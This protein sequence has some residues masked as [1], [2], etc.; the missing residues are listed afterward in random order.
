MGSFSLLQGIFPT[1]GLNS[2]LPH[3]RWIL[4]QLSHKG[5][6]GILDW[7]AYPFSRESSRPR[8]QIRVSCAASRILYQLTYEGSPCWE[9]EIL[10][11]QGFRR[12]VPLAL[13]WLS[14]DGEEPWVESALVTWS[15]QGITCTH[16][17]RPYCSLNKY[18]WRPVYAKYCSQNW[19]C[20]RECVSKCQRVE[21][22]HGGQCKAPGWWWHFS[23]GLSHHCLL[24]FLPTAIS[25][26][27]WGSSQGCSTHGNSQDQEEPSQ[28]DVQGLHSLLH[29]VQ[30]LILQPH[31]TSLS[32]YL[33]GP[34]PHFLLPEAQSSS[35]VQLKRIWTQFS[36]IT[37]NSLSS[38]HRK[39]PLF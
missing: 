15:P 6:P 8:N 10:C 13:W 2:G 32:L 18:Y 27:I 9:G 25:L 28:V 23:P 26:L 29:F 34:W 5:S 1:Q 39:I 12:N 30:P 16:H 37:M 19:G 20:F 11:V 4:Y 33:K 31:Q 24:F 21:L 36:P 17:L 7:V 3:C 38:A 14:V 22:V 35:K